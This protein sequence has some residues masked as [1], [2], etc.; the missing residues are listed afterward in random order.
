MTLKG[1]QKE[2]GVRHS[3]AGLQLPPQS[4]KKKMFVI[5]FSFISNFSKVDSPLPWFWFGLKDSCI[6]DVKTQNFNDNP[7]ESFIQQ[8]CVN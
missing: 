7:G 6:L 1:R 8:V 3:T 2:P 5:L 4:W